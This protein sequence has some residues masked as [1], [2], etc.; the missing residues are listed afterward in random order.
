[1]ERSKQSK[2]LKGDK[3]VLE[4]MLK[5]ATRAGNKAFFQAELRHINSILKDL[6]KKGEICGSNMG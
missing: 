5:E 2:A 4:K 3:K 1:M 6:S